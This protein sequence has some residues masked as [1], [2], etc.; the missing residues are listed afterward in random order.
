MLVIMLNMWSSEGGSLECT[1]LGGYANIKSTG[2]PTID[3]YRGY[4]TFEEAWK[5]CRDYIDE[6]AMDVEAMVAQVMDVQ[7]VALDA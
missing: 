6:E 1:A 5:E 4:A 3:C 2:F 7:G